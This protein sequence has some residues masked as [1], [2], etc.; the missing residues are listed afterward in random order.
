MNG[1][2]TKGRSDR[3]W[4]VRWPTEKRVIYPRLLATISD[5]F[6]ELANIKARLDVRV[7][8]VDQPT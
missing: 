3:I 6:S 2:T 8:V 1:T 7:C 5:G 4:L